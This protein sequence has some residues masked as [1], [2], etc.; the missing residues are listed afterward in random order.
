MIC[1]ENLN[2][3]SVQKTKFEHYL[4][5]FSPTLFHLIPFLPRWTQVSLNV[6]TIKFVPELSETR[7]PFHR[8]NLINCYFGHV[9]DHCLQTK[10]P[11]S[12]IRQIYCPL[13]LSVFQRFNMKLFLS[14]FFSYKKR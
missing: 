8:V 11:K 7:K 4:L 2:I 9:L 10:S 3:I 14:R 12:K 5:Q 1:I 6:F 13:M